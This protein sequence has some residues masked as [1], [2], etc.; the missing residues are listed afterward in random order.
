VQDQALTVAKHGSLKIIA[1]PTP[2]PTP[3]VQPSPTPTPT[4][5][6]QPSPTPTPASAT[7]PSGNPTSPSTSLNGDLNNKI[8][9]LIFGLAGLGVLF[10]LIGAVIFAVSIQIEN[11]V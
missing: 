7:V 4:P 1:Q 11:E 5:I 9:L 3:T 6:V 2:T 10:I 8:N